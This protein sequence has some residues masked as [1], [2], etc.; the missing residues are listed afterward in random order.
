MDK[1]QLRQ[2]AEQRGW[3]VWAYRL[4]ESGSETKRYVDACL[5]RGALRTLGAL[6]KDIPSMDELMKGE[7]RKTDKVGYMLRS[8]M[9]VPFQNGQPAEGSRTVWSIPR[10]TD[11]IAAAQEFIVHLRETEA[12]AWDD[13]PTDMETLLQY[14][15]P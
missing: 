10:H 4:A 9:M 1:E 12:E 11:K 7:P 8:P 2:I 15:R 6:E 5:Y 13:L 3:K 14:T